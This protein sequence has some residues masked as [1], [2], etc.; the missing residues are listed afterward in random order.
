[1]FGIGTEIRNSLE[2]VVIRAKGSIVAMFPE[3][4]EGKFSITNMAVPYGN[5]W[6][7]DGDKSASLDGKSWAGAYKTIQEGIDAASAGDLILVRARTIA[8]SVSDPVDYAEALTI[9]SGKSGLSLV[10]I[11]DGRTQGRLPQIKKGSGSA[12]QLIIRSPGVLVANLGF[13]G[14]SATGGGILLESTA[15]S[16][17]DAFGAVIA[18]CHFKNCKGAT[19]T[20]AASG[21]AIQLSGAPWQIAILYNKFYK[22][23]GGIV[24][25]DTAQSVPQDLHIEGNS[26]AGSA[27][28][29]DCDIYLKGGSGP[30]TG[31][32][33]KGNDFNVFPALA[34]G[35]NLRWMDLTGADGGLAA[36]NYFADDK[37]FGA[38]GTGAIVPT[39]VFLA[40]NYD[41]GGLIA[42]V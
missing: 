11:A 26:F 21:G 14:G 29:V 35:A 22:N 17:T 4:T 16:L 38:T 9:G 15:A 1:M 39:T 37:T 12:A 5:V 20:D 10:G 32:V 41:E 33:I 40:G 36:G 31:L 34:S 19:A 7:V 28:A 30:G 6:Y 18:N 24:L 8:A 3:P 27:A 23:V 2:Q 13:N 25:K 42:R